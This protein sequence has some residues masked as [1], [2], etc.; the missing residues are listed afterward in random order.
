MAITTQ[1]QPE[2]LALYN[3]NNERTLVRPSAS[4][5]NVILALPTT[6]G[7]LALDSG[8]PAL[9]AT[10]YNDSVVKNY[11]NSTT[12]TA[13]T[14]SVALGANKKY[15]IELFARF[16]NASGTQ[17]AKWRLRRSA[18][19]GDADVYYGGYVFYS[20]D[21]A[22]GVTSFPSAV[23]YPVIDVDL[24]CSAVGTPIRMA[25]TFIFSTDSNSLT[26]TPEFAQL[27]SSPNT[28]TVA[29]IGMVVTELG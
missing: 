24:E 10:A 17:N 7:T 3:D 21:S 28:Q 18:G 12:Y 26:V 27:V 29:N 6:S 19:T 5:P 20:V 8:T 11:T 9:Q 15:K 2:G 23:S 1:I 16:I 25:A 13:S 14:I 4:A 22:T